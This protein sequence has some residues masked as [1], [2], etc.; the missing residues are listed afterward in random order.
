ME[1]EFMIKEIKNF[2]RKELFEHYHSFSNPFAISTTKI[3]ITNIVNYC[4]KHRNFYATLG[5]II[6]KTANQIDEF[7]YRY[8]E[9]RK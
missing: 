8:K 7:K 3:D 1:K 6:T 4:K 2:E 5:F 9:C